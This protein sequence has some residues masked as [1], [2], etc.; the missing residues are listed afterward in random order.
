[1]NLVVL[2]VA[3]T[4][5]IPKI[6]LLELLDYIGKNIEIIL[7]WN[8]GSW[9]NEESRTLGGGGGVRGGDGGRTN[10]NNLLEII[11]IFGVFRCLDQVVV[12][13]NFVP[14]FVWW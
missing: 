8:N 14:L 4:V 3:Y 2:H 1:M 12:P 5:E 10:N 6:P 9:C 13:L 11:I 7:F